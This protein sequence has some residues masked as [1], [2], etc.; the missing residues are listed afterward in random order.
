MS[1]QHDR[2]AWF[3]GSD[4]KCEPMPHDRPVRLVLLGPPGV[5]KGTQ[6]ALLTRALGPCHL[7]TGDLFRAAQC[8]ATP[9]PALQAALEGMRQ[10]ELVS[11]ALVIAM[12]KERA[13]CL[14][15]RGGFLLDGFPRTVLQARALDGILSEQ[16]VSLDAALNYVLPLEEVVARLSGRRTCPACKAVYHV[17][18]QPPRAEGICDHCGDWLIQRADDSPE[19]IR[20]RMHAYEESTRPVAEYY[21]GI[22]KLVRVEASG[23]PAQILELS[24]QALNERKA[25]SVGSCRLASNSSGV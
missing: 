2:V 5:G 24:L 16:A 20:V 9:S 11:D 4:V 17:A 8:L 21:E 23:S 1:S 22:G 19:S 15:C 25:A 12:V 10:G 13:R 6:A 7:S 14:R 18:T 3:E